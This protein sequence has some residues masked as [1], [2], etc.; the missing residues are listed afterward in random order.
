MAWVEYHNQLI[1]LKFITNS[2]RKT[3]HI[4]D[5]FISDVK[6]RIYNLPMHLH[7]NRSGV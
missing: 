5:K 6:S 7:N 4:S 3:I 2:S 1:G